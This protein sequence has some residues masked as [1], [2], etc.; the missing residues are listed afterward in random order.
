MLPKQHRLPLRD[1]FVSEYQAH[2]PKFLLKVRERPSQVSRFAVIV[3]KRV[4]KHAVQRNIIKRA[5]RQCIMD[6]LDQVMPGYDMLFVAK[7]ALS[8]EDAKTF[9]QGIYRELQKKSL[10]SA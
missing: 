3:S 6:R 7:Q 10:M 5:F 1:R 4:A 9:C 2:T 8:K